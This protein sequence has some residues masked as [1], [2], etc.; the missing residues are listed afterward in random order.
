MFLPD[1]FSIPTSSLFCWPFLISEGHV[2]SY[3]SKCLVIHTTKLVAL[4]K[5][6]DGN[7]LRCSGVADRSCIDYEHAIRA[8]RGLTNRQKRRADWLRTGGVAGHAFWEIDGE[9]ERCDDVGIGAR[10]RVDI[11]RGRGDDPGPADESTH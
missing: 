9:E 3:I 4:R 2:R 5:N 11:P 6:R 7:D 10:V 8:R 1:L